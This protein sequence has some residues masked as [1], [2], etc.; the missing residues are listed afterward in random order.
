M[1]LG[2]PCVPLPMGPS[3]IFLSLGKR[4]DKDAPIETQTNED[5]VME[6][7]V[8]E[9]VRIVAAL[10]GHGGTKCCNELG[11]A[12]MERLER[13]VNSQNPVAEEAVGTIQLARS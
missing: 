4:L 5:M 3:A 10:D 9:E 6:S 12:I 13:L 8:S 7:V 11:S 2:C 1:E